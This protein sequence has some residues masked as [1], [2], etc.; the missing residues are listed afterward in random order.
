MS[1]IKFSLRGNYKNATGK[2][3]VYCCFHKAGKKYWIPTEI[4]VELKDWDNDKRKIKTS[5]PMHE[6][7]N[8]VLKDYESRYNDVITK[9]HLEK[10]DV[11]PAMMI[12]EIQNYSSRTNFITWCKKEINSRK[13]M[14]AASTLSMH[15]DII[16]KLE[17]FHPDLNFSELDK[18]LILDHEKHLKTKLHNK[19]NTIHKNLKT[20][21]TYVRMA[22]EQDLIKKNPFDDIKLKT[23]KTEQISLDQDELLLLLNYYKSEKIPKS[24]KKVLRYFIFSCM[25]GLRISDVVNIK[26]T[27]IIKNTLVFQPIKT[28]TATAKVVKIPLDQAAIKLIREDNEHKIAGNI[29]DT[30]SFPVTNRI[31]K[32]I[33]KVEGVEIDIPISYHMSRHTF[34]TLFLQENPGDIA[35]LKSLMG[36]AKIEQTMVYV[37]IDEN[38]LRNRIKFFNKFM[39]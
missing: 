15:L 24:H 1:G 12:K 26:W 19:V 2:I 13:Q 37:H 20:I 21:K 8:I 9:Y 3:R 30:F 31:L 28:K 23:N 29:F 35:S 7:Y 22:K 38:T 11:S 34:A 16:N 39:E 25:T 32:D 10:K 4:Y 6:R 18:K 14:I 33:A 27:D 36:H 5:E 17:K